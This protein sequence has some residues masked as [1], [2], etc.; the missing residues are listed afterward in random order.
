LS[1][2]EWILNSV[3]DRFDE[4][5]DVGAFIPWGRIEMTKPSPDW[6][7]WLNMP[8]LTTVEAVCLSIGIDPSKVKA[9]IGP[10]KVWGWEENHLFFSLD[11]FGDRHKLLAAC[12]GATI[13][14]AELARWAQS[15]KWNIPLQLASLAPLPAPFF[16][17]APDNAIEGAI[18]PF[19]AAGH[20]ATDLKMELEKAGCRF[21]LVNGSVAVRVEDGTVA[22]K[23]SSLD[24]MYSTILRLCATHRR[25]GHLVKA[26]V[27]SGG[28]A[29]GSPTATS[30]MLPA[31]FGR[32]DGPDD[33]IRLAP[34]TGVTP[35]RPAPAATARFSLTAPKRTDALGS[36]IFSVLKDVRDAGGP[37]PSA[38]RVMELC[39]EKNPA[40][41]FEVKRDEVKFLNDDGNPRAASVKAVRQRI[42]RMTKPLTTGH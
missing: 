26:A 10:A 13:T 6:D 41:V 18:S 17:D 42:E 30:S 8:T 21:I 20:T 7:I 32:T 39:H 34:A 28:G 37:V 24:D 3:R 11:A 36:V 5:P 40:D 4:H 23:F 9:R 16:Q 31:S 12:H 35:G 27:A 38:R 1:K 25:L 29:P 19:V 2:I 15:V 14:P 22:G 33:G